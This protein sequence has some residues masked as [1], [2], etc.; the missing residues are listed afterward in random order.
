M[1]IQKRSVKADAQ[2]IE[3]NK[4]QTETDKKVKFE[5]IET[6]TERVKLPNEEYKSR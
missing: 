2:I 4:Y 6:K 1:L 5:Q 3:N